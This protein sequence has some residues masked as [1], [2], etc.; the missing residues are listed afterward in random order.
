MLTFLA[1][2]LPSFVA[3]L[4]NRFKS[5]A[6]GEVSKTMTGV[7]PRRTGVN[8]LAFVM[9][10]KREGTLRCRTGRNANAQRQRRGGQTTNEKENPPQPHSPG[11][12]G[13][14]QPDLRNPAQKVSNSLVPCAETTTPSRA[15]ANRSRREAA[16][17]TAGCN[18]GSLGRQQT[19]VAALYLAC[20]SQSSE[21]NE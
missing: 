6:L 21:A 17:A 13:H 20:Y 1:Q 15:E 11:S 2:A 9:E 19:L 3:S 8:K 18:R 14:F 12:K 7:T 16:P 4:K 5:L 10:G